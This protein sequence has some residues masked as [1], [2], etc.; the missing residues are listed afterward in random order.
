MRLTYIVAEVTYYEQ[1]E[2]DLRGHE[3]EEMF[4]EPGGVMDYDVERIRPKR[5]VPPGTIFYYRNMLIHKNE[6]RES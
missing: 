4:S 5:Y 1:G 3:D 6:R 2:I